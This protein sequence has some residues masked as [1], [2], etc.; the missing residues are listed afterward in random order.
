MTDAAIAP[1]LGEVRIGVYTK[2]KYL[3]SVRKIEKNFS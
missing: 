1:Q 3:D 2:F